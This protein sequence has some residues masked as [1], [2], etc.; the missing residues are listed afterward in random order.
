MKKVK[1]GKLEDGAS[2][3]RTKKSRTWFKVI[4]KGDFGVVITSNS[5]DFSALMKK[6]A[7]VFIAA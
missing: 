7:E 5:S 2:F 3:K 6:G 1:I 4:T